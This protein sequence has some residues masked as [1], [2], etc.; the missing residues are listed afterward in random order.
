VTARIGLWGATQGG[1]TTFLYALA[2]ATFRSRMK[3]GKWEVSGADPNS[4]EFLDVGTQTLLEGRFPPSTR[5]TVAYRWHLSG[6]PPRRGTW[7]RPRRRIRFDIEV[8]DA[9]G[10]TYD[11][12]TQSGGE[13]WSRMLD[14]TA[15][16]DGLVY[17]HDPCRNDNGRYLLAALPYLI[18]EVGRRNQLDHGRLPHHLAVC[19]TKFDD[20]KVL[21]EVRRRDLLT[22]LTPFS[23]PQVADTRAWFES[24]AEEDVIGAIATYFAPKRVRY[25]ATSA[26]GFRTRLNG[27]I[28]LADYWANVEERDGEQRIV[29]RI[30]PVN[31]LEPLCWLALKAPQRRK[32][33]SPERPP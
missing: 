19:I 16:C 14:Y 1:K 15:G 17:L 20:P 6:R 9:P 4:E 3:Y 29:G 25:F 30:Y 24:L 23:L 22:Q 12:S 7:S 21:G 26:I 32:E 33:A 31:V 8:L 27:A 18:H 5:Q 10:G 28:D 2:P 13:E 11:A